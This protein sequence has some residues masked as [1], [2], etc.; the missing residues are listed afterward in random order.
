V[1]AAPRRSDAVLERLTALHPKLIDLAL[2]RIERLLG[3]LGHPEARLPPVVHVAGTNGKGSVVAFMKAI[4]E[5]AGLTVHAYISPHL[6]RFAERIGVAGRQIDEP[7]LAAVLEECEAANGGR[8]ITF[9]EITTAAAFLAFSRTPADVALLE[10][11]LG[12][13][14]DA[15]NVIARPAATVITPIGLDHMTFLGQTIDRIAFEKAGILKAG[16]PCVVGPQ[17]GEAERVIRARAAEIGVPVLAWSR[18]WHARR[19]GDGMIYEDGE[20]RLAL[21]RPA[22]PGDHQIANAGT[23]IAA[24]RALRRREIDARAITAGL[25]RVRWPARLERLTGGRYVEA[26][27]AGWQLWLDGGHNPAAAEAIAAFV[28]GW[29]D[30][31]LHL[32]LGML[33]TRDPA[34]FLAPLAPS[35]ARL[36]TLTI[37]GERNSW[38]AAA[39]AAAARRIG[40]VAEPAD[41]LAA[42]IADLARADDR[43]ARILICGSLYLAGTVLAGCA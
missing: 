41:D 26:L 1:E 42:A 29:S 23:A 32:V 11:G 15:T 10:T 20:H 7:A 8:P 37:R 39:A 35:I 30:R 2:D 6:V 13:R 40:L 19:D 43:P 38:T 21:P 17:A 33:N 22:L 3:A 36:R 28:A 12:G 18:D 14:F 9:F 27:P 4:C 16:A 31:P 5:A 24:L 25:R 34:A